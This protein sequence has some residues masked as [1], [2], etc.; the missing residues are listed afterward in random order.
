MNTLKRGC[1]GGDVTVLQK[2]LNLYADGIFGPLTEESVIAF[3]VANGL[4]ADGIVGEKTWKALGFDGIGEAR[5]SRRSI[6]EII[7]HC[8]DTREGMD[9]TVDDIRKWHLQRGFSDIGYHYVV[10]RDGSVHTGRNVDVSGAHCVGHN[11]NSIGVCYIGGH[12]AVGDGYKDTRTEA[13]KKALLSLLSELKKFYP[14]ATIH[15][16]REFAAKACPCFDAKAEY[17]N[18]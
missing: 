13:Q 6:N 17:S 14:S 9:Y 7:V 18:I 12:E 1:R 11:A 5:K 16:H 15:G 4:K 10:Y 3:Q 2:A 8:S